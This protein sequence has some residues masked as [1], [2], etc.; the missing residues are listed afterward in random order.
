MDNAIRRLN[1]ADVVSAMHIWSRYADATMPDAESRNEGRPLAVWADYPY[2]ERE[3]CRMEPEDDGCAELLAPPVQVNTA[4]TDPVIQGQ[5]RTADARGRY[6]IA[7][8]DQIDPIDP[9]VMVVDLATGKD[10]WLAMGVSQDAWTAP[11]VQMGAVDSGLVDRGRR[12]RHRRRRL[13]HDV[14]RAAVPG[15]QQLGHVMGPGRLRVGLGGDGPAAR[16]VRVHDRGR[17]PHGPRAPAHARSRPPR[18]AAPPRRA[19]RASRSFPARRCARSS[20]LPAP[21]AAAAERA[22]GPR[23]FRARRCAWR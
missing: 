20:A 2:D 23:R 11:Q 15:A 3:A 12:P 21:T 14:G 19:R 5:I 7:E 18:R 13:P 16:P 10:V 8:V 4:A 22:C 9:N 17:R 1:S 6:T